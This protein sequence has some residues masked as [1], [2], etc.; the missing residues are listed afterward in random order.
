M[1]QRAPTIMREQPELVK[2]HP[3]MLIQQRAAGTHFERP[4]GQVDSGWLL[5]VTDKPGIL[6]RGSS[7]LY[8]SLMG[9]FLIYHARWT[10]VVRRSTEEENYDCHHH[11]PSVW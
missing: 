8:L 3:S 5:K 2:F 6:M 11:F 9:W 7:C 10:R 1:L 4:L